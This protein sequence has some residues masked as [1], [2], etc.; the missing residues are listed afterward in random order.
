[1]LTI[2]FPVAFYRS[3]CIA[4]NLENNSNSHGWSG[5]P[6]SVSPSSVR[7]AYYTN[8]PSLA[9]NFAVGSYIAFGR[10]KA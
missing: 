4:A 8:V 1:M 5:C 3:P 7:L 2:T 10:W 9:E 6:Y